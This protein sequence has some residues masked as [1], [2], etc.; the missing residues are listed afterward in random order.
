MIYYVW[1]KFRIKTS[2]RR[3]RGTKT[4]SNECSLDVK[5]DPGGPGEGK[6]FLPRARKRSLMFP[7][8]IMLICRLGLLKRSK[9]SRSSFIDTWQFTNRRLFVGVI[10]QHYYF[11]PKAFFF[12]V[13]YRSGGC[14][15]IIC[16]YIPN[17]K[18]N[19]FTQERDTNGAVV[20]IKVLMPINL[21]LKGEKNIKT[22]ILFHLK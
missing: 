5:T 14:S 21:V 17:D 19:G 3:W 8:D 4:V 1:I 13:N 18:R 6:T 7:L 22:S 15:I 2:S 10:W 11:Y 20:I 9:L 12:F 16:V